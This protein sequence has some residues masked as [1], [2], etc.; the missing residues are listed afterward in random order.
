MFGARNG[1][2]LGTQLPFFSAQTLTK[3]SSS[4]PVVPTPVAWWKMGEASGTTFVDTI[5]ANNATFTATIGAWG[6]V[7]GFPGSVFTFNGTATSVTA[8][9][10]ASATA[11]N[12]TN[13]TPFSVS[14]W[15]Q[16]TSAATQQIIATNAT[17]NSALTGWTFELNASELTVLLS[18]TTFSNRFILVQSTFTFVTGTLYHV[19]FTYDGSGVAAGL[20]LYIN[21]A[22]VAF[23]TASDTLGGTSIASG[24]PPSIAASVAQNFPFLGTV[25]DVRIWNTALQASLM[26]L[27]F[28][29]GIV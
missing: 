13:L 23:S 11:T 1:Q 16:S 3:G 18:N 20:K 22:S 12:F 15:I 9:L 28:S 27:V 14:A 24:S 7:A 5:A 6:S 25:A 26:A 4:A 8:P 19:A 2:Y 21:G 17:N 10:T 29:G